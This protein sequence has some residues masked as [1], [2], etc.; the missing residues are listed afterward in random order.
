MSL[1]VCNTTAPHEIGFSQLRLKLNGQLRHDTCQALT[2][3][4]GLKDEIGI[5]EKSVP[6][7]KLV[8]L[9]MASLVHRMND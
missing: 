4:P 1:C 2:L 6:R 9:G 5:N 7:R 8:L 3:L